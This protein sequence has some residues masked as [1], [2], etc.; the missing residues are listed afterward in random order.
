V[1]TTQL[2]FTGVMAPYPGFTAKAE[3]S[4]SETR[5]GPS[6]RGRARARGARS[7]WLIALIGLD[8]LLRS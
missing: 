8:A 4:T 2:G 6:A 3:A 7:W 1:A 5:R